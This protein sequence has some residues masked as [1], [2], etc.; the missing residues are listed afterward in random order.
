ML[1]G[2]HVLG[3]ST[4]R[5]RRAA[6]LGLRTEGL[7]HAARDVHQIH[8]VLPAALA[9]LLGDALLAIDEEGVVGRV[10]VVVARAERRRELGCE[11][12]RLLG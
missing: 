10:A 4:L 1:V 6:L 12:Q 3:A 11:L 2:Q 5:V 7:L 8:G 9:T